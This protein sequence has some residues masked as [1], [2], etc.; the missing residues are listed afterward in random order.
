MQFLSTNNLGGYLWYTA[1]PLSRYQGWFAL[2][3]GEMIKIVDAV[4]GSGIT[5]DIP[6]FS[7]TLVIENKVGGSV[8]ITLDIR[9]SYDTPTWNRKY[10]IQEREGILW[11]RYSLES[12]VLGIAC[13]ASCQRIDTWKEQQYPFDALRNSPPFSLWVYDVLSTKATRIVMAVGKNEDEVREALQRARYYHVPPRLPIDDP[14]KE[15]QHSLLALRVYNQEKELQGLYGGL[16]WFFQFWSRDMAISAKA[17]SFVS[18]K[19]A[20]YLLSKESLYTIYPAYREVNGNAST[21]TSAD[22]KMF[23][24]LRMQELSI[25]A[26]WEEYEHNEFVPNGAKETWMDTISRAGIRIE[27][28]ALKLALI[29]KTP[30]E[31]SFATRVRQTFLSNGRL[32]DGIHQDGTPDVIKRPNVFLAAYI[33]PDL[34]SQEEWE[35]TFDEHLD[36]LWLSWGGLAT[37]DKNDRSFHPKHTGEADYEGVEHVPHSYHQGDSWF[38]IN[39]IAAIAMHKINPNK[40]HPY[41][42]KIFEA[43]SNDILKKGI[44]GHASELSSAS[45]LLPGGSPVQLWSAATFMELYRELNR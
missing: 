9:K 27:L 12:L 29:K 30:F 44:P 15:A 35:K 8:L 36:S 1:K 16:P 11:V 45:L 34:L 40:Y 38:W 43:S 10:T 7:N 19:E 33:Y 41:I 28:Q 42:K 23:V 17:L 20:V 2:L 18:Q 14:Y 24:Q 6:P 22:G 5:M 3:Q 13:D 25:Q 39:N 37:L 21:L 31:T 26:F 4:H 32:I